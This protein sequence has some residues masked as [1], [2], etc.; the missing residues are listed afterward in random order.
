M[1]VSE[2]AAADAIVST[3][4]VRPY[5]Y[6]VLALL[7]LGYVLNFADRQVVAILAQSIKR[8]LNLHDWEI[9]I[10]TGPAIALFYAVLGVPLAYVADRVHRVRF[11]VLCLAAWSTLTALGGFARNLVQLALT[12][13]GVSIAEGGGTPISASLLADYFPPERRA[14]AMGIY[15][16]ATAVGVLFG[17]AL[18]GAVNDLVGWRWAMA[19]AGAPG[20]IVALVIFA[21]LREPKRGAADPAGVSAQKPAS[22]S[23]L[24][25]VAHLW[26]IR[27]YRRMVLACAG[28]NMSVYVLLSWGPSVALRSFDVTTGQV[29]L[30]MGAGFALL[31]IASLTGA[32]LLADFL[33][34][35]NRALPVQIMGLAQLL[36]VPLMIG[37]V[38]APSFELFMAALSLAYACIV[39]HSVVAWSITQNYTPADM[40]ASAAASM[41]LVFNLFGLGLGPPLVG[42]I[43]DVL[44]QRYGVESLRYALLLVA[45]SSSV[46]GL[47]LLF[48]VA[49]IIRKPAQ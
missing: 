18:G 33:N 22:G 3:T 38:A 16:A 41:V 5:A 42:F 26:S 45:C 39:A 30:I 36:V 21:T 23:L 19:A 48:W 35:R 44:T 9:G 4:R 32:G 43:S 7:F 12:R 10:L 46:A 49:P 24:S 28:A 37:T 17:F 6:Y 13:V 29:G 31:G 1:A 25:T 14:T 2:E 34:A 40:R 8:D 27:E 47:L 11:L 20:L 15:S